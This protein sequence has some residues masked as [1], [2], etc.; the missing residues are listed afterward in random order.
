M[1][2]RL[3]PHL[4]EIQLMVR[5]DAFHVGNRCVKTGCNKGMCDL[6]YLLLGR[7]I[8]E[9]TRHIC[10]DCPFTRPVV[11]TVW[12]HCMKVTQPHVYRD[13]LHLSDEHFC[14]LFER[15]M[16]FGVTD[17]DSDYHKP[18]VELKQPIAVTAAAT[19]LALV[20]R[21]HHNALDTR[22]PPQYDTSATVAR[23]FA[24]V[25]ETATTLRTTAEREEDRIYTHYEGWLPDE[26][27]LPTTEWQ[28]AWCETNLLRNSRP[29]TSLA[30]PL[31]TGAPNDPVYDDSDPAT[32]ARIVA[33]SQQC[34]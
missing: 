1:E 5:S 9:T 10:I 19:N 26:E 18:P 8:P 7:S 14:N 33:R 23:I 15:R 2:A 13:T 4:L 24:D 17:Y 29:A 20:R 25:C 12:R 16:I 27:K 6:C 32:A 21:R 30:T 28:K 22:K 3:P 11:S 31:P 34:Y